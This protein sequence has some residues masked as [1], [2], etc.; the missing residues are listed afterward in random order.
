MSIHLTYNF[1]EQPVRNVDYFYPLTLRIDPEEKAKFIATGL[2]PYRNLIEGSHRGLQ[3]VATAN[4]HFPQTIQATNDFVRPLGLRVKNVTL[5]LSDSNATSTTIHCDGTYDNNKN[6]ALLEARL[7][8]YEIAD[9]PGAIR[10]WDQLPIKITEIPAEQVDSNIIAKVVPANGN[11]QARVQVVADCSDDLQ[12]GRITWDDIPKPA[13]S[14]VSSCPS[15]ILR[16]NRHHHVI[17]GNGVRVTVSCQLV[18]LNGNPTGVWDHIQKNIHL[19]G[20]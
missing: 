10:W 16:T 17:Q 1:D 7:S 12:H 9:A 6:P 8:Y 15:A 3:N 11:F 2:V 14:V 20:A 5:F 13:F 19:V 4:E 18:F